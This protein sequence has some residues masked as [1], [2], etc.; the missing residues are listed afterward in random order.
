MGVLC[1][2]HLYQVSVFTPKEAPSG[3]RSS[4]A[5]ADLAQSQQIEVALDPYG[6]GGTGCSV[7]STAS[8]DL[9]SGNNQALCCDNPERASP[10]LPVELDWLFPTLPPA[11]DIPEFRMDHIKSKLLPDLPLGQLE[12]FGFVVID[13][14]ADLVTSLS[15]RDGSH[16]E[17]LD[18]EPGTKHDMTLHTARYV[19]TNNSTSSNCDD[20]HLG[21]AEGT[22]IKLP[23]ECG[24]A[25]YGVVHSIKESSDQG[26]PLSVRGITPDD[27]VVH[28]L[29][30]SYDFRKVRRA[31]QDDPVYVRIDYAS[32]SSWWQEVV[33]EAPSR[34]R[35]SAS[36]KEKR[37]WSKS[38]DT[39]KT[40]I[41]Q[42]RQ[43]TDL[44]ENQLLGITNPFF[45]E[46]IYKQTSDTCAAPGAK[47]SSSDDGFLAVSLE[48]SATALLR[49]GYTMVGTISPELNLE[50]A[51]GFFDAALTSQGQLFVD[52]SG[53]LDI[54]GTLPTA[55]LFGKGGVTDFGWS[56]PGYVIPTAL[57]S[58]VRVG[59]TGLI[60]TSGVH[61]T[62]S[63][64]SSPPSPWVL[65]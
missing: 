29:S 27:A 64:L 35:D 18:C 32:M 5:C 13:G 51:H 25:T 17:F 15:K 63:C 48:G 58:L 43:S 6:A 59:P 38:D 33:D 30:F 3:G 4:Y 10:F 1:Q 24:Y 45:S 16:I 62:V 40:K 50:E 21:G 44:D 11:G 46:V 61:R 39:W 54:Q 12:P 57:I 7:A 36:D 65:R 37:F 42:I 22:V 26:M 19:C 31:T 2:Q 56:Q 14:P 41:E 55:E 20:V 8:G 23:D 9:P 47:R 49:W 53:T 60:L 28:E 52:G 34:K